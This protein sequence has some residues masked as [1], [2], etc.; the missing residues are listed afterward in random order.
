[1]RKAKGYT[2]TVTNPDPNVTFWATIP[3]TWG[4]VSNDPTPNRSSRDA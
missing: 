4:N 2:Y 1:M 3:T